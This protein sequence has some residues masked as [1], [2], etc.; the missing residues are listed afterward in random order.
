MESQSRTKKPELLKVKHPSFWFLSLYTD[1][2]FSTVSLIN[3]LWEVYSSHQCP[4]WVIHVGSFFFFFSCLHSIFYF[5]ELPLPFIPNL[6]RF[7]HGPLCPVG[8]TRLSTS[9][10]GT[11]CSWKQGL[12]QG[13]AHDP[14]KPKE[15]LGGEKEVPSVGVSL[16][17]V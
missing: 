13:W 1:S 6:V 2:S 16:T 11:L 14:N 12:A 15:C 7:L 4:L 8:C 9:S 10:Q 3:F 5:Q 17:V